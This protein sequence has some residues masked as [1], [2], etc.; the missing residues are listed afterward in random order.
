MKVALAEGHRLVSNEKGKDFA[1]LYGK[2]VE[3]VKARLGPPPED[4][5]A[6]AHKWLEEVAKEKKAIASSEHKR[7]RGFGVRKLVMRVVSVFTVV[8]KHVPETKRRA[9]TENVIRAIGEKVAERKKGVE[10]V[11]A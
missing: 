4:S 11:A 1:G 10:R 2:A 9:F 3:R 7:A 8:L 5:V 6:Q